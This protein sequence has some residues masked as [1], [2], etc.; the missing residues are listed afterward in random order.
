MQDCEAV[1]Y[2][3]LAVYKRQAPD[4]LPAIGGQGLGAAAKALQVHIPVGPVVSQVDQA[5]LRGKL[6]LLHQG[7]PGGCAPVSY[8]HLEVYKRQTLYRMAD[9]QVEA[10][11]FRVRPTSRCVGIPL[12]KMSIRSG[13]LIGAIIRRGRCIIP[14]GDDTIEPGDSVIVV[15]TIRGLQELNTILDEA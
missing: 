6:G 14:A 11:E 4:R 8:T 12:K 1:S 2:T 15:T 7:V 3:H 5:G 9:E 13:I 10:L